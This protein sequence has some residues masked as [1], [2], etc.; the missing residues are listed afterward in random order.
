MLLWKSGMA[1]AGP[2]TAGPW[3]AFGE[4]A[5]L[6]PEQGFVLVCNQPVEGVFEAV[7]ARKAEG[8]EIWS[9]KELCER[10]ATWEREGIRV[11]RVELDALNAAA[12]ALLVPAA[13]VPRLRPQEDPDPLKV[14]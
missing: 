7:A 8:M 9:G 1:L 4:F 14:F 12:A 6:G 11:E 3:Y 13:E 5:T 2:G 10:R